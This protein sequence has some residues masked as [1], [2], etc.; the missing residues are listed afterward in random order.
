MELMLLG[1]NFRTTSLAEREAWVSPAQQRLPNTVYLATCNRVEIYT[2]AK[3]GISA[4]K[5]LSEWGGRKE[6]GYVRRGEAA[7]AHLVRVAAGLDAMVLGETEVF[8]QIKRAYQ[9]ALE[10]GT[11]GPL[12]NFVFQRAFSIAK[13]IRTETDISRLPVSV[14]SVGLMLLDQIF[15]EFKNVRSAVAGLGAMGRQTA[16]GLSKRGVGSLKLFGR[17]LDKAEAFARELPVSAPVLP[18]G[19]LGEH[20]ADVDLLITATTQPGSLVRASQY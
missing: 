16:I 5:L 8:G 19:V 18:L 7:F 12:L 20:L 6:P 4:D 15:G 2:A 17:D 10:A 9:K 14:S 13:K 11:T 1:C 3:E